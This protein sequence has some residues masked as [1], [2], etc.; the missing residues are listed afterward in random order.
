MD[1][2]VPQNCYGAAIIR[3]L[4]FLSETSFCQS[5]GFHSSTMVVL[6]L[7]TGTEIT[8]IASLDM[9]EWKLNLNAHPYHSHFY[10]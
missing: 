5:P 4:L 8:L 9:G 2:L 3:C 6:W 1:P 10:L 7:L